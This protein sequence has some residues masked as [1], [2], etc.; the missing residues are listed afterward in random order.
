MPNT[1]LI[2]VEVLKKDDITIPKTVSGKD[3]TVALKSDGTVWTWGY[4]GYGQLGVGDKT[5]RYKPTKINIENVVDI[6]AGYN[7]TLLVTKDGK[8]YSFGSNSYGQ[9]GRSENTLLPKEIPN[10]ENIEK[11][12]AGAYH[13]MAIGKD[14]SVYT[15]GYNGN[16]QLGNGTTTSNSEPSKIR[17]TNIT[18]IE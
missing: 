5:N 17:L 8:I 7:H 14:G 9:L 15:W 16:G 6:S 4:N 18:K 11:V 10:L 1:V 3:F 2:E 13:S 12:S